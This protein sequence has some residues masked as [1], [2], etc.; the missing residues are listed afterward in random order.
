MG[1]YRKDNIRGKFLIMLTEK[2]ISRYSRHLLLPEIGHEGQ[3]KL[4]NARVLVI[5][6]GGLGCPV[7][8]YLVAAGVGKIGIVDFDRVDETNLQRQV[9]FDVADIGSSKSEVAKHKLSGQNPLIEIESI[10]Q[11]VT[12]QNA[13]G[14]FSGYD[15]VVDGTD[16]FST[17]Y[18][19]NDAC[20]L[21]DKTLVS[22]SIFKFQGQI[23]VFNFKNEK[24]ERG[25][26]YRCLF[27]TPPPSGSILS[28]SETGVLGVLP[29]I[30]G[31]LMANEVIKII[32]GI[33]EV[34]SGKVLLI[35]ALTMNFQTITIARSAVNCERRTTNSKSLIVIVKRF[36]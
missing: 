19:V 11:R 13:I 26:T 8:M 7:L 2:E 14:I 10:Q 35:D 6:A 1:G 17:R 29:G 23:S 32:A 25:P 27:P 5:G 36:K 34:L 16:N 3:Q 15:I 18:L 30:L 28:C 31:T 33:G 22:G 4:K 12:N 24:G 20:V 9:L 21:L